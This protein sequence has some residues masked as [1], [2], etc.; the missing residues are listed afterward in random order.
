MIKRRL[1]EPYIL[2]TLLLI[3]FLSFYYTATA[4]GEVVRWAQNGAPVTIAGASKMFP[5][6]GGDGTGGA[7]V[8]WEDYRNDLT[9]GDIFG[10]KMDVNGTPV[11]SSDKDVTID[12]S[13]AKRFPAIVKDG[14]SGAF[15]VWEDDRNN[16]LTGT[17]IYIQRIG[18]NGNPIWSEDKVVCNATGDQWAPQIAL[19]TTGDVIVVWE[20]HRASASQIYAQRINKDTGERNQTWPADGIALSPASGN[21]FYPAISSDEQGGGVVVW[22]YQQNSTADSDIYAQRINS[23][24]GRPW[25]DSGIAIN[26]DDVDQWF[27]AI[28]TDGTNFVITWEDYRT[29]GVYSDIYAKGID[30]NGYQVF[31]DTA[32]SSEGSD[33]RFPR[34]AYSTGEGSFVVVWEDYRNPILTDLTDIYAKRSPSAAALLTPFGRQM[35]KPSQ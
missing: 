8:V 35:V 33:Q 17:D 18:A 20:D 34:I 7:F 16:G 6:I 28:A 32:I 14:N 4:N 13:A 2:V 25:G 21:Q 12:D 15:V 3:P 5:V 9:K 24:G 11:F 31:G 27:P 19:T 26:S 22:E 30:A 1:K 29:D 10:Q 23:S